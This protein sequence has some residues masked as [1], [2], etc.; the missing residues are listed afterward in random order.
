MYN[1]QNILIATRVNEAN[2]V[3]YELDYAEH[4]YDIFYEHG[5]VK[6]NQGGEQVFLQQ[7][8]QQDDGSWD[9]Q[10]TSIYLHWIKEAIRNGTIEALK[11]PR[12]DEAVIHND[13]S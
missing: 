7:I 12:K 8:S 2:P 9:D 5:H 13:P 10:E 4:H 1:A 6:V 3:H 11:L